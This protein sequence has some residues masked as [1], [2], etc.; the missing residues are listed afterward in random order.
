MK[1]TCYCN[2]QQ[3]PK[4][5]EKLF[6]QAEKQSVFFSREWLENISETALRE[7]QKLLLACVEEGTQVHALL[8]IA[9]PTDSE[10]KE[11]TGLQHSYSSLYS[12]ML[13]ENKEGEVIACLAKGIAS[14]PF[15]FLSFEPI[16]DE[17]ENMLKLQQALETEGL[18]CYRSFRF[19]N[20]FHRFNGQ[21]YDEY[22]AERPSR[23]RNTIQRKQRKLEREHKCT[24]KLF[25]K[26]DAI[27]AMP[28]Y[29]AAYNA[30][31]KAHEQYQNIVMGFMQKFAPNDWVRIAILSIDEQPAAVQLWFVVHGKA[32]IFRLAHDQQ[33][34]QY[35]PGSILM[36]YL[37]QH[38]IG[39]DKATEIDF[40][41]GN[42]RY[43]QDWMDQR[44]KRWSL[45]CQKPVNKQ[46]EQKPF[47]H[48]IWNRIV[49]NQVLI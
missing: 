37:M 17:D 7:G 3:L 18:S 29:F 6:A 12:F 42:D 46:S 19:Y 25:T 39:V 33:W 15:Q 31:W 32:S 36:A 20:W 41:T 26:E 49:N 47:W 27:Q 34:S 9:Q 5:C 38:V 2:W 8:P 44:R 48:R 28:D 24:I 23:L 40:L 45:I 11:W 4:S 14:L 1:F 16:S 30:S 43:K 21:S 35:S 10:S 13:N 22:M